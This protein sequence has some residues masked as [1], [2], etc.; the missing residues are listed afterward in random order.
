MLPIREPGI[1]PRNI[2]PPAQCIGADVK[3]PPLTWYWRTTVSRAVMKN[4]SLSYT[5]ARITVGDAEAERLGACSMCGMYGGKVS[6]VLVV[7]LRN[8]SD[9]LP[10]LATM[11]SWS[12]SLSRSP[13]AA[14][15]DVVLSVGMAVLV[16]LVSV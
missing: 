16:T 6:T 14:A 7:F 9:W 13:A 5:C 3:P 1:S 15:S 10:S 11:M 8:H 4:D 12:P 2:W